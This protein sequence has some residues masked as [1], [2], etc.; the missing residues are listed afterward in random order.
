M[1]YTYTQGEEEARSK[2]WLEL[3]YWMD[4]NGYNAQEWGPNY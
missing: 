4:E 1:R 3:N 2:K